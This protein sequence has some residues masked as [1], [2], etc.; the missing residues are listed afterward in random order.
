VVV[1]TAHEYS[2]APVKC[3]IMQGNHPLPERVI[4]K[5]AKTGGELCR[6]VFLLGDSGPFNCLSLT[7]ILVGK[8]GIIT[9]AHGLRIACLGGTYDPS[10]YSSAEV[11]PVCVLFEDSVYI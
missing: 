1:K 4:E 2:L 11:A 3:Y 9:T 8:S 7:N 5:F 6:D 10:I